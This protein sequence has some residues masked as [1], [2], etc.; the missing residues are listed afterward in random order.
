VFASAFIVRLRDPLE[1]ILDIVPRMTHF[2]IG[3]VFRYPL[4][5]PCSEADD[6]V[7]RLPLQDLVSEF[8]IDLMS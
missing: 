6:A 7:T 5:I 2:L 4:Q 1:S 3:D 8:L